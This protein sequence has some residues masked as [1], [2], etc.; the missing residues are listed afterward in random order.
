MKTE[1]LSYLHI[2][3]EMYRRRYYETLKKTDGEYIEVQEK[4][5]MTLTKWNRYCDTAVKVINAWAKE[6]IIRTCQIKYRRG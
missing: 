6:D 4:N 5:T 2:N 3:T 1:I